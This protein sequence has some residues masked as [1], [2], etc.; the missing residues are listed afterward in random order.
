MKR[1]EAEGEG[2]SRRTRCAQMKKRKEDGMGKE[3]ERMLAAPC[4]ETYEENEK[5]KETS[6]GVDEEEEKRI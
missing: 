6:Q 5:E 4:H 1:H 3:E 2:G